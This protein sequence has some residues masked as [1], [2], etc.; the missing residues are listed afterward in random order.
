M[1]SVDVDPYLA[2]AARERLDLIG[3]RPSVEAVDATGPLPARVGQFDRIVATVAV[4]RV[5][6]CEFTS[7]WRSQIRMI[8]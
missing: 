6:S 1:T 2:E 8:R 3:L 5:P 7:E 4:R